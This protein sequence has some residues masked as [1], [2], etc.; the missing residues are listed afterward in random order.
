M[1]ERRHRERYPD[2]IAAMKAERYSP[3]LAG[4]RDLVTQEAIAAN[5]AK[6][7]EQDRQDALRRRGLWTRIKEWIWGAR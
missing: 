2:I 1:A 6:W 5:N 3:R 4:R 7:A